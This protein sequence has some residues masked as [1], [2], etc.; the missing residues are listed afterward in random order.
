MSDPGRDRSGSNRRI[1]MV[2]VIPS[3]LK[4]SIRSF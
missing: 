1:V 4:V 2:N 3:I